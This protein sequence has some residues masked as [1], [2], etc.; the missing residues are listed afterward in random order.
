MKHNKQYKRFRHFGK[1]KAH[2]DLG[3]FFIALN[4]QKMIRG[5]LRIIIYGLKW[6]HESLFERL[7]QEERKTVGHDRMWTEE[8]DRPDMVDTRA[9]THYGPVSYQLLPTVAQL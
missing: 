2:M 3:L 1:A 6:L 8:Y 7:C 9:K 4:L 5:G